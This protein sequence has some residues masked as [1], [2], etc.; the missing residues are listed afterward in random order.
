MQLHQLESP[1]TN[2]K[3]KRVGRGGKRGTYS[4]RGIK[5]QN[6][7]AG[8][9]KRP[10]E[11]DILKK[12][13]K[14]RGYQFKSFRPQPAVVNLRDL[15]A[16]FTAGQTVSPETLL[17]AGL[18]AR[19]NGKTPK[20]KVLGTGELKKKLIFKDVTFSKSAQEKMKV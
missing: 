3:E 8:H 11:R 10:A 6:A 9:R 5:G 19:L 20:V 15:E 1:S 13:P 14:L 12:I 2:K 7:R 4:G 16:S 18:I 17:K